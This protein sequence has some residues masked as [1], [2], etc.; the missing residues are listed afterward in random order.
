MFLKL[1]GLKISNLS[2]YKQFAKYQ[3]LIELIERI[4]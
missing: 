4:K 1:R 3:F 2:F